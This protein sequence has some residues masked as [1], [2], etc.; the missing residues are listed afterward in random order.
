MHNIFLYVVS[1]LDL[2]VA[3]DYVVICHNGGC[4]KRN[5]PGVTFMKKCYDMIDRRLRKSFKKLF[6][7]HP[8]FYLRTII[9]IC[10]PFVSRKFGKKIKLC[11]KL[12]NLDEY[13]LELNE[14]SNF[15]LKIPEIVLEYDQKLK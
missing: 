13:M 2:L 12:K 9:T 1:T 5:V 10:K 4:L 15:N 11:Y 8:T 3:Q 6:I 7:V 14:G